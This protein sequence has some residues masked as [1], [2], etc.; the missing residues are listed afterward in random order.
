MKKRTIFDIFLILVLLGVLI[1]LGTKDYSNNK[2]DDSTKFDK[3]YSLVDKN[4]IFKYINADE[5][6]DKIKNGNNVIFI[7]S[8]KNEWANYYASML[9]EVAIELG[10]NEI[11]YYD[12]YNDRAQKTVKYN[13]IVDELSTYLTR[14]DEGNIKITSPTLIVVKDGK[15]ITFDDETSYAKVGFEPS[16]YWNEDSVY[17]KKL[18][19]RNVFYEY[20]GI[21]DNSVEE[22]GGEDNGGEN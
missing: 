21:E 1:F 4:N 18:M 2:K 3:E 9:N 16:D 22:V 5:V 20:L 15:V 11:G 14:D 10:V 8:S 17:N 12:F 7:G 19:L 13:K 6:L